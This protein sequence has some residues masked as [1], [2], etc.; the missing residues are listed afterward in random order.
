MAMIRA[1]AERERCWF[2]PEEVGALVALPLNVSLWSGAD[3]GR[4]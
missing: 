3:T 4:K 1:P 2:P